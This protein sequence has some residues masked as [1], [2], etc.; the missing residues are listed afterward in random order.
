M[1]MTRTAFRLSGI[2]LAILLLATSCSTETFL[3]QTA[4]LGGD[5][6]GS[7]GNIYVA[8]INNTPYRA[9]FTYGTYNNTDQTAVP[10]L[11]QFVGNVNGSVLGGNDVANMVSIGCNRVFSIGDSELLRLIE[12]NRTDAD[13]LDAEALVQGVAFSDAPLGDENAGIATKGFA[14]P[15]R[16][17]LGVDFPCGAI[18]VIRFE[19]DE[20][21]EAPF[22]IDF[23][24]I[25]PADD[26]RGL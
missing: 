13:T 14:P 25:P 17:L 15:L 21:G 11:R 22:R 12:E 6:A 23:E 24:I 10:A 3:N 7:A 18:L 4:S 1:P 20:L 19:V 8:F 9:I 2:V 26:A 5:T 16:A